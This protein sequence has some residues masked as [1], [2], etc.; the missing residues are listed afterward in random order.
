MSDF[1]YDMTK[2]ENNLKFCGSRDQ[3]AKRIESMLSCNG[4]NLQLRGVQ[5]ARTETNNKVSSS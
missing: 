2:T 4:F 1:S 5:K 3:I